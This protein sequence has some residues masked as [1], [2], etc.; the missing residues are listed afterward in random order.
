MFRVTT[1]KPCML[2]NTRSLETI[3][4]FGRP[5]VPEVKMKKQGSSRVTSEVSG[6]SSAE[7]V[8]STSDSSVDQSGAEASA[9]AGSGSQAKSRPSSNPSWSLISSTASSSSAPTTNAFAPMV[10]ALCTS[11]S[12][13]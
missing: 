4:A 6:R 13:R 7:S 3:A 1:P 5:V 2:R 9:R 10:V 12:R 8:S 11:T